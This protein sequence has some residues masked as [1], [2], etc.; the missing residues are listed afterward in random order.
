MVENERTAMAQKVTSQPDGPGLRIGRRSE[1]SR[2]F[3][4]TRRC[5]DLTPLPATD[6]GGGSILGILLCAI[7]SI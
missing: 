3:P 5:A 7:C 1:I 2:I 6:S 4:V